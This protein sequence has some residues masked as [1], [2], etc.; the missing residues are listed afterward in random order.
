M[1][2]D[3]YRNRDVIADF[4]AVMDEI[5]ARSAELSARVALTEGVP[6]GAGAREK[7]DVIAPRAPARGCPIHLFLH[8]GYWRSGRREDHRLVAAPVL[9]A[10]GI[11]VLAGYDL[12]PGV[13]LAH[14]VGQVRAA[15]RATAAMAG[16]LGADPARLSVSGHSAGA[17]LASYLAATAPH[18]TAPLALPALTGMLLVSGLYDLS[19]IPTSFLKDETRMTVAEAQAWSP[20]RA[21]HRPVPI[22]ILTRGTRETEPFHRQCQEMHT[23]LGTLGLASEERVEDGLDHL[24]VVLALADPGAGLGRRLAD[25]VAA[26]ST[27]QGRPVDR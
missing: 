21:R 6:Y 14:I 11:A 16:R 8:G 26:P 7:L 22:R 3:P 27:G 10:G 15:A 1:A 25:L 12:M 20:L 5:A 18:E 19:E 13:G 23:L 4:D 24:R 2:A 9:A 17:H